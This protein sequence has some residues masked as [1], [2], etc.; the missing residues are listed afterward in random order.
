[1]I[2]QINTHP[3]CMEALVKY[4]KGEGN[5]RIQQMPEP[6]L[7]SGQVLMEVDMCGICGTDL[8]VYHDT[9]KNYPPVILG[10]EFAGRVI[11]KGDTDIPEGKRFAVLGA[12]AITCGTCIHCLMG[13]FMFCKNRRGMGHGVHGAF[14]RYAAVRPDQLF[15]LPEEVSTEEGA[16]VEPLAAAVHAVNDIANCKLGDKA[17][18]S[19]PGPIGLLILKLLVGHGVK[20]WVIGTEADSFRLE[21]AMKYGAAGVLVAGKDPIPQ[22]LEEFT[23]GQMM[24]LTFEV[25]GAE[26]SARNCMEALRPKGQYIQVGHFGKDIL[27]P[28]DLVAFRE[29]QVKGSV[30]YTYATWHRTLEILRQQKVKVSDLITHRLPLPSW[31]KGFSLMEEKKALKILLT[32]S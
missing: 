25:A 14:T 22:L 6:V 10:H 26:G 18:V 23:D 11:D 28:W 13:N 16:L 15:A 8:H 5:V 19:G 17:I 2:R 7:S 31:E 4:K 12:T 21:M 32:P 20:T 9:F 27:L 30:G 3:T 1:M 29:I 24:D